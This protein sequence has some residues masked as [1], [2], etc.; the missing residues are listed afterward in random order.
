[1]SGKSMFDSWS[2]VLNKMPYPSNELDYYL[3][4]NLLCS[5]AAANYCVPFF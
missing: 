5:L 1:M 2:W 3:S 4:I